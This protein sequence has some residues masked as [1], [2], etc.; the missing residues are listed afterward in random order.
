VTAHYP[1]PDYTWNLATGSGATRYA[2][3]DTFDRTL[4]CLW[5]GDVSGTP[6]DVVHLAYQPVELRRV[7]WPVRSRWFDGPTLVRIASRSATARRR[8]AVRFSANTPQ[9]TQVA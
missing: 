1:E 4:T 5:Q 9:D 7:R 6:D 2:G 3:L 8:V